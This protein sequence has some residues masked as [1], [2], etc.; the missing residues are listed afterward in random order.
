[1]KITVLKETEAGEPRV[2]ATPETVKK[3]VAAGA[4]VAV[5]AG[6]GAGSAISDG[7]YK[8]AGATIAKTAKATCSSAVRYASKML[9]SGFTSV[10]STKSA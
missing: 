10:A 3:F 9:G 7:E 5:E 4:S 2:A 1:M 6:A 8:D